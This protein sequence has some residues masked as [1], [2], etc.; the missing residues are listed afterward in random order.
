MRMHRVGRQAIIRLFAH[1]DIHHFYLFGNAVCCVQLNGIWQRITGSYE[2][3]FFFQQCGFILHRRRDVTVI[4]FKHHGK[5]G[6]F[7]VFA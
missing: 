5:P 7:K 3:N 1:I 2:M 4:C 6:V